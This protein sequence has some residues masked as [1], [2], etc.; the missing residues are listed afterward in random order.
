M[1]E[2]PAAPLGVDEALALRERLRAAGKTVVFT[3]GCFDVLHAGHVT[4]L[5]WARAQGDAL[6]IGLNSDASVRELKGARRPIVPFTQRRTVLEALRAVDAVA[7][8]S[9]RSPEYLIDLLRPDIH[10]KSA[11]Y[12]LEDLPERTIVEQHGGHVR[13]APHE[14]GLSTTDIIARILAGG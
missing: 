6:I 11:Q 2:T 10:V 9:E 4:Y 3:N 14:A 8:F 1:P 13:L 12:R 5:Q 7:G